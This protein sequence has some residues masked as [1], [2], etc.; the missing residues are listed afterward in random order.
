MVRA[1]QSS[2]APHA[3]VLAVLSAV[4]L[5]LYDVAKKASVQDNAVLPVLLACSASGLLVFLPVVAL[6][7]AAPAFG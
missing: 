5:G 6:S 2:A 7:L 4:F 1:E 3:M